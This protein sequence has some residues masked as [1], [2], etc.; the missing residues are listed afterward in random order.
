LQTLEEWG[1]DAKNEIYG[2]LKVAGEQP[3]VDVGEVDQAEKEPPTKKV[4]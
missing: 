2:L 3:E 1:Q 4:A